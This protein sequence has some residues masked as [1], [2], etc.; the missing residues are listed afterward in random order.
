DFWV[1]DETGVNVE[2]EEVADSEMPDEGDGCPAGG[3]QDERTLGAAA[4]IEEREIG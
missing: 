1:E 4:D 3:E 2:V